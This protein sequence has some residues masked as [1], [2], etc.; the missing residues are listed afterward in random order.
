MYILRELLGYFFICLFFNDFP[1]LKFSVFL[2]YPFEAR[3]ELSLFGARGGGGIY[4]PL[5]PLWLLLN[6]SE[7]HSF[8]I[9]F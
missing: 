9:L 4:L 2:I 5:L 3:S 6:A 1:F 8:L 7:E